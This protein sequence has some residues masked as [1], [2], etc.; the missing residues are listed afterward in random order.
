MLAFTVGLHMEQLDARHLLP[1]AQE[2]DKMLKHLFEIAVTNKLYDARVRASMYRL[3]TLYNSFDFVIHLEIEYATQQMEHQGQAVANIDA[4]PAGQRRFLNQLWKV[5][6]AGAVGGG[7]MLLAGLIA[8]PALCL[9]TGQI[10]SS[11]SSFLGLL[12]VPLLPAATYVTSG[13]L[14]SGKALGASIVLFGI[15]G[16]GYTG[17]RMYRRTMGLDEVGFYSIPAI[18]AVGDGK[19]VDTHGNPDGMAADGV[20]ADPLRRWVAVNNL[21]FRMKAL[22]YAYVV[23]C[24]VNQTALDLTLVEFTFT[25][26]GIL[27]F[28]PPLAIPSKKTGVFGAHR[29]PALTIEAQMRAYTVYRSTAFDLL[30]YFS[31]W[32]WQLAG[33]G[34]RGARGNAILQPPNSITP[35]RAR[36]LIEGAEY[37]QR[38]V[39][40]SQFESPGY[41]AT[42]YGNAKFTVRIDE[43]TNEIPASPATEP[44]TPGVTSC[45]EADSKTIKGSTLP[46]IVPKKRKHEAPFVALIIPQS[47]VDSKLCELACDLQS[48]HLL[49]VVVTN[50]SGKSIRAF[51]QTLRCG[52]ALSEL[53]RDY[54]GPG[55][56]L[57]T[58]YAADKKE[59]GVQLVLIL[60][61]AEGF[62]LGLAIHFA[63]GTP[64]VTR[65]AVHFTH[66]A[67]DLRWDA[68]EPLLTFLD[69][70]LVF[71]FKGARYEVLS[72]N[73][74]P[75]VQRFEVRQAVVA[76]PERHW[77]SLHCAVG[78]SGWLLRGADTI[79]DG[80]R[81][82][83]LWQLI[84]RQPPIPSTRGATPFLVQ[85]ETLEQFTFGQDVCG[86][87]T[88]V[89]DI[90]KSIQE[91]VVQEVGKVALQR[92]A[93]RM[94]A[95]LAAKA[96]SAIVLP[97]YFKQ[98]V[99]QLDNVVAVLV[100]KAEK[101]GPVLA[102]ILEEHHAQGNRPVSFIA[103]ST[104][105]L[106]VFECLRTLAMRNSLGLVQDVVLLGATIVIDQDQWRQ[107]ARVTGG[108]LINVFS[109]EDLALRLTYRTSNL[110]LARIAGLERVWGVPGVENIDASHVV[111]QHADYLGRLPEVLACIPPFPDLAT[112]TSVL[113]T[114]PGLAV[115]S[116]AYNLEIER[117]SRTL[118]HM[119]PLA[120]GL[121]NNTRHSLRLRGD[122]FQFGRWEVTPPLHI[123][124]RMVG[125]MGCQNAEG[126]TTGVMGMVIFECQA[127]SV[128]IAFSNPLIGSCK[129]FGRVGA[130]GRFHPDQ[131][132]DF[133]EQIQS[134]PGVCYWTPQPNPD[135]VCYRLKYRGGEEQ[136]YLLRE[137]PLAAVPALEEEMGRRHFHAP[138]RACRSMVRPAVWRDE[139]CGFPWNPLAD[140]LEITA[141]RA[142]LPGT[143]VEEEVLEPVL[144]IC[145][146]PAENEEEAGRAV[147]SLD[148]VPTDGR[149]HKIELRAEDGQPVG[150]ATLAFELRGQRSLTV[151]VQQANNLHRTAF[152]A[153]AS[154]FF[155]RESQVTLTFTEEVEDNPTVHQTHFQRGEHPIWSEVFQFPLC[156]E[157]RRGCLNAEVW[158]KGVLGLGLVGRCL[159]RL[160]DVGSKTQDEFDKLLPLYTEDGLVAG[161][162]ALRLVFPLSGGPAAEEDRGGAQEFGRDASSS[163]V[164]LAASTPTVRDAQFMHVGLRSI[165]LAQPSYVSAQIQVV[166]RKHGEQTKYTAASLPA[167]VPRA[168]RYAVLEGLFSTGA[169]QCGGSHAVVVCVTNAMSFAFDLRAV[170]CT[171][172]FLGQGPP[173]LLPSASAAVFAMAPTPSRQCAPGGFCPTEALC[174]LVFE[175]TAGVETPFAFAMIVVAD[176]KRGLLFRPSP[177]DFS[178]EQSPAGSAEDRPSSPRETL[179]IESDQWVNFAEKHL[180][181]KALFAPSAASH[182]VAVGKHSV[183]KVRRQHVL[184]FAIKQAI[185]DSR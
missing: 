24:I 106:L 144:E 147:V 150:T 27:R 135:E 184:H 115:P 71:E 46:A 100:N 72:T 51:V 120:I 89:S 53:P 183:R 169:L 99:D 174:V 60:Q 23:V 21:A 73:V 160:E 29:K 118:G 64:S 87:S 146:G 33:A 105:A 176:G 173:S 7:V 79:H 133:F 41:M 58:R 12:H 45:D 75:E 68:L 4:R 125:L 6:T 42:S 104:G 16:A 180:W 18:G 11:L 132:P 2:R 50:N 3:S 149:L 22:Q 28:P 137:L 95:E 175:T 47:E 110:S 57:L 107:V 124:A 170:Y 59:D 130:P 52:R 162:L 13:F 111:G 168:Q 40:H 31:H 85:W 20:V 86:E 138:P 179:F 1:V 67:K 9:V 140:E 151:V 123:P 159:L 155:E 80:E 177:K 92:T 39:L 82:L 54:F 48:A 126:A 156:E 34:L 93:F 103:Y 37:K 108:R 84:F 171:T 76:Q 154:G 102:D 142:E 19:V 143:V 158:D 121:K 167:V 114:T 78:V 164:A 15:G 43:L 44:P 32:G 119:R 88:I 131:L 172:R 62:L 90:T 83:R 25:D 26:E 141:Y 96:A 109:S 70:K 139:G 122:A 178:M 55:E 116:N 94:F 157:G 127:F 136:T 8:G 129:T 166:R 152:G 148:D 49:G 10:L 153:M 181:V 74:V 30:C 36:E 66:H 35:E 128:A 56:A 5:A 77:F 145:R 163:L 134:S 98:A 182:L 117:V 161:S 165:Y 61:G 97:I 185:K 101:A 81:Q 112:S 38:S 91:N 69:D 63:F 14:M 65:T 113:W 17:Y